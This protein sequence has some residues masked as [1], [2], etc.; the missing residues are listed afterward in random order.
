MHFIFFLYR[1]LIKY[2][3]WVQK[4][5]TF[6]GHNANTQNPTNVRF[7]HWQ[8]MK[9]KIKCTRSSHVVCYLI[10]IDDVYPKYMYY[11]V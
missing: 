6:L 5:E 10:Y 7:S 3:I 1:A 2:Q 9:C 11:E 8:R 4:Y